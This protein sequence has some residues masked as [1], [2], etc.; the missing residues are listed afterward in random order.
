[1]KRKGIFITLGIIIVV[2]GA[3]AAFYFSGAY[4][5]LTNPQPVQNQHQNVTLEGT[6]VCLPHKNGDGPTTLECAIGLQSDGKY[7]GLSGAS[8]DLTSAA[9]SEE[10]VKV[11]GE[12]QEQTS[13]KYTMEGVIA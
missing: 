3:G 1:M 6:V 11:S 7:Y 8:A 10:K 9:G 12:L 2:I 5:K 13:D 4:D